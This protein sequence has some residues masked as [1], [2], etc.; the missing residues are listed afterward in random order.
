MFKVKLNLTVVIA[1]CPPNGIAAVQFR[2]QRGI[3]AA[4]HNRYDINWEG[5][6]EELCKTY[7]Q[8]LNDEADLIL[9][10]N[11]DHSP[12]HMCSEA[13][14]QLVSK[15]ELYNYYGTPTLR[16]KGYPVLPAEVVAALATE[17]WQVKLITAL[18]AYSKQQTAEVESEWR[19]QSAE[20][21]AKKEAQ[22]AEQKRKQAEADAQKAE[23]EQR[24]QQAEQA[25]RQWAEANGSKLVRLRLKG[26]FDWVGLALDEY[27]AAVLPTNCG[28]PEGYSC[29]GDEDRRKPTVE[30]MEAFEKV[31]AKY[32]DYECKL[33]WVT[34]KPE[35][36]DD[37]YTDDTL[38][39]IARTEIKITA[40]LFGFWERSVYVL[41]TAV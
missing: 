1:D 15:L 29:E 8:Y 37:G 32:P 27:T 34:Y 6:S 40:T 2:Q 9:W 39:T 13:G 41:P 4:P 20:A 36:D 5:Q 18:E 14:N 21:A 11:S 10:T 3:P 24:K 28:E 12:H 16:R 19:K 35:A 22:E 25:L 31:K 23:Q 7:P 26:E 38:P 30:E 17:G 33:R